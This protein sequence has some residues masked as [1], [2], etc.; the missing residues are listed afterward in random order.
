MLTFV[1]LDFE[2]GLMLLA[3]P[4]SNVRPLPPASKI[5]PPWK[6]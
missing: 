3:A 2:K 5:G 6:F 1:E 4:A